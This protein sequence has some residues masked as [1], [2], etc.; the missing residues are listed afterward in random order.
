MKHCHNIGW[1]C[2][3]CYW[4][5]PVPP[6]L[7]TLPVQWGASE[8]PVTGNIAT[9]IVTWSWEHH[10]GWWQGTYE[11]RPIL[12]SARQ[13]T[14]WLCGWDLCDT[15]ISMRQILTKLAMLWCCGCGLCSCQAGPG[16]W[17]G[18]VTCIVSRG[19][20]SHITIRLRL[21][22]GGENCY[23]DPSVTDMEDAKSVKGCAGRCIDYINTQHNP[24]VLCFTT[25]IVP[26]S[27]RVTKYFVT[28]QVRIRSILLPWFDTFCTES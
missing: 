26:N 20:H 28:L 15:P 7:Y 17:P 16:A 23:S 1:W 6:H 14:V 2:L 24:H 25:H 3:T 8:G 5:E 21:R 27:V 4:Q 19:T 10:E 9:I 12:L 18:V 22:W 11:T 13:C